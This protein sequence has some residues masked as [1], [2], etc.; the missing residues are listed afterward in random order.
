MSIKVGNSGDEIRHTEISED[1][2]VS[3]PVNENTAV[4]KE[5]NKK[6]E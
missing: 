3:A 2:G 1:S 5:Y 4:K 6:K